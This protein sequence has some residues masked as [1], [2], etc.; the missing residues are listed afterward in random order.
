MRVSGVW[1]VVEEAYSRVNEWRQICGPILRIQQPSGKDNFSLKEKNRSDGDLKSGL[2]SFID[3]SISD[4]QIKL[5]SACCGYCISSVLSII[6]I[7]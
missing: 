4:I 2:C 7:I 5:H 6:L 1:M 3:H